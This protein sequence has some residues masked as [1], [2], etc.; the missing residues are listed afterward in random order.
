MTRV[1]GLVVLVFLACAPPREKFC[2][3][4]TR[5]ECKRGQR[6][7]WVSQTVDCNTL[8][9]THTCGNGWNVNA[10]YGEAHAR[11]CIDERLAASCDGAHV[12]SPQ[13]QPGYALLDWESTSSACQAVFYGI[14]IQGAHCGSCGFC[15]PGLA[16][17]G[18]TCQQPPAR[19][20]P[21]LECGQNEVATM[22][23]CRAPASVDGACSSEVACQSGLFCNAGTCERARRIGEACTSNPECLSGICREEKCAGFGVEGDT[24]DLLLPCRDGFDCTNEPGGSVCRAVTPKPRRCE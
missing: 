24:C 20:T 11:T 7:G 21:F 9:V 3:E 15:E 1:S 22:A 4:L 17:Q 8:Q 10:D 6:C 19:S 12:Q 16:C 5:A 2:E 13:A 18:G 23:Q 14:A